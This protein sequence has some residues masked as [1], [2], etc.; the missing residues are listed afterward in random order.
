MDG[1][2]LLGPKTIDTVFEEQSNGIDPA[3]GIPLRFGL[4]FALPQQESMPC[5]PDG[6]AVSVVRDSRE[7]QSDANSETRQAT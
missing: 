7:T 2:C 1:V 5:I 6:R 4:G 3:L